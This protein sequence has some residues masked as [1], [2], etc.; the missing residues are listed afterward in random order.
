MAGILKFFLPKDKIFYTLF[1]NASENLELLSKLL[2]KVVNEPDF[3]KRNAL[4]KEME[5][6]EHANDEVTHTIFIELGKNFITPFD[7]EDIHS[8]ASALDDIADYIY[9]SGKKINFYKIDPTSDQ[10]IQKTAVAIEEAV[11]AVKQAVRELRN[12]KN[13][14]KIVECVIKINSAENKADEIFDMSIERLFAS[15]VDAKELIKMR[16]LYQVM[17]IVTD[18]CED[19]GN[20][21]E[22]IVVKYA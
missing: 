5:D 15:D 7:R 10:G 12:L 4:I 6:L 3:G 13:T 14:Q 16:E 1:E 2:V 21:I 19:A 11:A 22:S 20:V 9:A 8:L 18:K 17:E